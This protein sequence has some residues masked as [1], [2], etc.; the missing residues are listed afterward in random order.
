[1]ANETK[2]SELI[3]AG[4]RVRGVASATPGWP[5]PRGPNWFGGCWGRGCVLVV[6]AFGEVF[7]LVQCQ[8][9]ACDRVFSP[10]SGK[11]QLDCGELT[12]RRHG[13]LEEGR[14]DKEQVAKQAGVSASMGAPGAGVAGVAGV[15]DGSP[16]HP[17]LH[18]LGPAPFLLGA[19]G[20]AAGI[21]MRLLRQR[22]TWRAS[23]GSSG[24]HR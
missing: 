6:W 17:A 19:R 3:L 20:N 13:L 11:V 10:A 24:L 22:H 14:S 1:M 18:C 12:C 4:C 15:R 2:R 8:Y 16:G 7:R 9:V 5:C 23:L 21:C